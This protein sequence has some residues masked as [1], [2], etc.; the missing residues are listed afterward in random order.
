MSVS[1]F[2]CVFTSA[3]LFVYVGYVFVCV[4]DLLGI[5]VCMSSFLWSEG[6]TLCSRVGG[7]LNMWIDHIT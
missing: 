3:C 4:C 5:S 1:L 2:I 7:L 6:V